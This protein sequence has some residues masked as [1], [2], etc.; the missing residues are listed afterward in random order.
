[1]QMIALRKNA[2]GTYVVEGPGLE[3]EHPRHRGRLRVL[4]SNR[5]QEAQT[6]AAHEFDEAEEL[7]Q[8]YGGSDLEDEDIDSDEEVVGSPQPK[9][10]VPKLDLAGHRF[11][12]KKLIANAQNDSLVPCNEELLKTLLNWVAEHGGGAEN[13]SKNGIA[14]RKVKSSVCS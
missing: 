8:T 14:I 11:T 2:V 3:R 4:L 9:T 7:D 6:T 12:Q 1:M 10:F 5:S 13:K